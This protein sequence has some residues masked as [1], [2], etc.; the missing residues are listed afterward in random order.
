MSEFADEREPLDEKYRYG[1]L[2]DQ[3]SNS[4]RSETVSALI[5]ARNE[6]ENLADCLTSLSWCDER[7]VV[8]DAS[9]IDA[10]ESLARSFADV[11]IVREFVDFASQRNAGLDL[12]RSE[13]VFAVDADERS[14]AEQAEE[15]RSSITRGDSHGFRVP[16]RSMVLGRAF[17]FS[18]TQHDKPLRLFRRN[19]GRWIGAVHET[20]ELDGVV[21]E[22]RSPL[23]HR[24]IA[25][26]TTFLEKIDRYTTLEARKLVDFQQKP[27]FG[28]LT[29]RPLWT[30]AKLY[31]GKY[32]YRDGLEGMMFCAMSGVS[33]AVR[34]WKIRE[35]VRERA[36]S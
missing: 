9:S 30:F 18:G 3:S 1:L 25:N 17:R 33:V 11:T 5:I 8:V 22:L 6:A 27:R 19:R 28:D 14:S 15:I 23:Q 12:A 7:V 36:A 20:V 21:S 16:I 35:L 13:W 4:I 10:T 2:P 31:F 34:S 32:G 26:M 29:L 24:T